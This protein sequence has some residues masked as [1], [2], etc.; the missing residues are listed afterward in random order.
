MTSI[1]GMNNTEF[2]R[3]RGKVCAHVLPW[4]SDYISITRLV[5]TTNNRDYVVEMTTIQIVDTF[6][7]Q[8]STLKLYFSLNLNS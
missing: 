6:L 1:A 4:D 7:A 5:H 2:Q 8:I 3:I